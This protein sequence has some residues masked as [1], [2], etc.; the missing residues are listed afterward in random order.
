MNQAR[1]AIDGR[2]SFHVYLVKCATNP[3][4]TRYVG[5]VSTHAS[6]DFHPPGIPEDSLDWCHLVSNV[7]HL[8]L[9]SFLS[10]NADTIG[11][12]LENVR[13]PANGSTVTYCALTA[14]QRDAAI[15]AGAGATPSDGKCHAQAF[16]KVNGS[17]WEP[18]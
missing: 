5:P 10:A 13:T 12:R 16:D 1:H 14:D 4:M 15:A 18:A 7:S 8:D 9:L 2:F 17:T 6:T 11:T 3:S